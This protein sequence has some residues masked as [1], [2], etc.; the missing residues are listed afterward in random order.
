[1]KKIRY[2]TIEV[3]TCIAPEYI[4]KGQVPPDDASDLIYEFP[5]LCEGNT[6]HPG[7]WCCDCRW[8]G[9]YEVEKAD[10]EEIVNQDQN[11]QKDNKIF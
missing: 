8:F 10:E 9:N 1:M 2:T 5:L 4:L 7:F 6:G 3:F 11:D